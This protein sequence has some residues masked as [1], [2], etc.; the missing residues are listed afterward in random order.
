MGGGGGG[1]GWVVGPFVAVKTNRAAPAA[2]I[3][4]WTSLGNGGLPP[5]RPTSPAPSVHHGRRSD[6]TKSNVSAYS[7]GGVGTGLLARANSSGHALQRNAS[8]GNQ[9]RDGAVA[10]VLGR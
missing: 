5:H 10:T 7:S 9:V 4:P 2:S 8:V 1:C 6:R 3:N